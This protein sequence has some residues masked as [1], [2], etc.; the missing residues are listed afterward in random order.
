MRPRARRSSQAA[1]YVALPGCRLAPWLVLPKQLGWQDIVYP[2]ELLLNL[3][4]GQCPPP[5]L[6][7]S[8]QPSN[9]AVARN[10]FRVLNASAARQHP[11][12]H[13]VPIRYRQTSM[14]LELA[15]GN[16]S[17]VVSRDLSAVDC[18]CR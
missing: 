8:L 15:E 2:S 5:V 11:D 14:V 10:L 3:C 6:H 16:Y 1:P 12:V 13:C 18:G 17:V 7:A 4:V 9:H